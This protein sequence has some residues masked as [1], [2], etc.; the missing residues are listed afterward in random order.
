MALDVRGKVRGALFVAHQHSRVGTASEHLF[1]HQAAH[2]A[3]APDDKN[4]GHRS[5]SSD[6]LSHFAVRPPWA[7]RYVEHTSLNDNQS[8]AGRRSP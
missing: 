1:E 4:L 8:N 5:S 6:L 2:G 3:R 7:M